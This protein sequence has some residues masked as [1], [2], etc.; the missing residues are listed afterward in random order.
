MYSLDIVSEVLYLEPETFP[1]GITPFANDK[2]EG[3]KEAKKYTD[4]PSE[5][6]LRMDGSRLNSGCTGVS[7]AWCDP[8]WKT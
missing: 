1:G 4:R 8:K 5:L 6:S 7:V 3:A 2:Q